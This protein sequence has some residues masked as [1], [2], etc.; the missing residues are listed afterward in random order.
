MVF[1]GEGKFTSV[2]T[3]VGLSAFV[4]IFAVAISILL[5]TQAPHVTVEIEQHPT[6]SAASAP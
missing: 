6:R 3:A 4:K 5:L 2:L 1:G